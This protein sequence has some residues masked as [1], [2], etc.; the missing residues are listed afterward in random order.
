MEI[1]SPHQPT[2]LPMRFI[3]DNL[4][5]TQETITWAKRSHQ[6]SLFLELDFSKAYDMVDW[7]C[8]FKIVDKMGFP[9]EFN[10]MVRLLFINA[11][12]T[13]KVNGT[14]SLPFNNKPR[15]R[16]GC[17]LAPYMFL[18]IAQVLSAMVS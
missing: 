16:Q 5:L 1:I 11:S 6:S 9:S 7:E 12:A 15:V 17:P 4:M 10:H 18:I 13:V 2:F 8:L 3:L 14:P